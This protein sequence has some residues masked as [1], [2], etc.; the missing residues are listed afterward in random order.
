M[1][2]RVENAKER[3]RSVKELLCS[4]DSF[5][6]PRRPSIVKLPPRAA[7]LVVS[8]VLSTPILFLF[9]SIFVGTLLSCVM[10]V[11]GV[12]APVLLLCCNVYR[13]TNSRTCSTISGGANGAIILTISSLLV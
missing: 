9:D 7:F 8:Q 4:G 3:S 6:R 13:S 10:R 1:G 2:S 11:S 5:E 12:G